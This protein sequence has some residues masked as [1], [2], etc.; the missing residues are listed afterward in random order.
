MSVKIENFEFSSD[1]VTYSEGDFKALLKKRY[2]T[3][4]K[5]AKEIYKKLHGD[6]ST[7]SEQ[8]KEDIKP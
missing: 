2:G 5:R 3:T 7:V 1:V 8:P 6:D 4:A